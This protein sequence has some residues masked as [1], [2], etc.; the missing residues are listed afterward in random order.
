LGC[1]FPS[2]QFDQPELLSRGGEHR[3]QPNHIGNGALPD[4]LRTVDSYLDAG[5]FPILQTDPDQAG[6]VPF[7]A[8]GNS[9][10]GILRSNGLINLI[11]LRA[12][13]FNALNHSN[14]RVPGVLSG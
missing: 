4:D 13:F 14:F 9:G 10:I 7:Q 2:L 5:A 1:A 11:Q 12:E 3:S 6:F 8:F